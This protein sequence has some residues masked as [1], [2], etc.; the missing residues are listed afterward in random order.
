MPKIT[1]ITLCSRA[2]TAE[3][4]PMSAICMDVDGMDFTAN[5]INWDINARHHPAPA[6]AVQ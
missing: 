4:S 2:M 3:G 6:L 1:V 5:P